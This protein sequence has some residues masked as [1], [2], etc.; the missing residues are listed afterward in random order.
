MIRY[1]QNQKRHY[2]LLRGDTVGIISSIYNS[3]YNIQK[4][5]LGD[6]ELNLAY[7]GEQIIF[8]EDTNNLNYILYNFYKENT[9]QN[10][11]EA[12]VKS[13]ILKGST[14]YRNID[15]GE[16]LDTFDWNKNLELVSVKA[17][18]LITSNV[19]FSKANILTTSEEVELRAFGDAK[20][21]LDLS[22]GELIQRIGQ[23]TFT[24]GYAFYVNNPYNVVEEKT[25]GFRTGSITGIKNSYGQASLF[26]SLSGT[27]AAT[28]D[29]PGVSYQWNSVIIRVNK[30]DLSTLDTAGLDAYLKEH[31]LVVQYELATVVVK[32]VDSTMVDQ[33]GKT[34]SKL[35]SFNG[36]THISTEVTQGSVHPTVAV[37]VA[38]E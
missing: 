11:L 10:T 3:G 27:L 8:N 34:I 36:T 1:L 28:G 7:L 19:D 22:T 5:Y 4:F 33:D 24:N 25:I 9:I 30:S 31:P 17:P 6:Q 2:I 12:P 37:E 23:T 15:T 26:S 29:N 18:T 16:I 32:T 20:D 21:E 35:N 14:K 38:V 13:V